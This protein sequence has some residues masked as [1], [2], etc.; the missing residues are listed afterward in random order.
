M[1]KGFQQARV[2]SGFFMALNGKQRFIIKR[3]RK[4]GV[5]DETIILFCNRLLQLPRR[6]R[7]NKHDADHVRKYS[8]AFYQ[9]IIDH[10]TKYKSGIELGQSK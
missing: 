8:I 6:D 10:V 3:F 1:N 4:S 7:D 2:K 9:E 5:N